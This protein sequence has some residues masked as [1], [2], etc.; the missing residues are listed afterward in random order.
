MSS[1]YFGWIKGY[2]LGTICYGLSMSFIG[3]LV[4]HDGNHGGTNMK[5]FNRFA[6]EMMTV[7]GGCSQQWTFAH[8]LHHQ[9]PNQD[10]DPD[11]FQAPGVL[12]YREDEPVLWHMQFQHIYGWMLYTTVFFKKRL[13]AFQHIFSPTVF[14]AMPL[15]SPT[16]RFHLWTS[17]IY[18]LNHT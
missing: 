3:M 16:T 6:G 10:D 11:T 4:M 7:M 8:I 12:R 2:A 18:V 17:G 5:W 1:Y 13:Q 15:P 9:S 14:E